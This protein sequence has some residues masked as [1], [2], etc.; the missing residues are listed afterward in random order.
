[1]T[2]GTIGGI[3]VTD[4]ILGGLQTTVCLLFGGGCRAAPECSL[5]S[6][7]PATALWGDGLP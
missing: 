3:V 1:M 6:A 7:P 4:L 2:G 5:L